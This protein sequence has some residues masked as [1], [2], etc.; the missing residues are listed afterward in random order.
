MIIEFLVALGLWSGPVD[1]VGNV[2]LAEFTTPVLAVR[3]YPPQGEVVPMSALP[4]APDVRTAFDTE[5]IMGEVYYGA[6]AISK[7]GAYGYVT[8]SNSIEAAREVA[9]AECEK[10]ADACLIYAEIYP[11]G[12]SEIGRGE[13]TMSSEASEIYANPGDR[14][15]FRAMAISEDGAYSLVWG[16]ATQQ[17]ADNAAM[18]DCDSYRITDLQM[19]EMPCV[20]LP[21][22]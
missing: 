12:Y 6:F 7:D 9:F 8:G 5:F 16:H 3:T 4:L 15:R 18:T 14:P 19:R 21:L 17:A 10:Y 20:L 22:K 13:V 1:T 2:E 11:V